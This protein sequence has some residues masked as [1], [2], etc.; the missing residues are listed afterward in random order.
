MPRYS[1]TIASPWSLE[2]SFAYMADFRHALDWDPSVR[3]ATSDHEVVD[4]GALFHLEVAFAGRSQHL[5]YEVTAFD[6]PHSLTLTAKTPQL[7]SVDTITCTK[8]DT[9][10]FVHYDASLTFLGLARVFNPLLAILFRKLAKNAT[11]GLRRELS[12]LHE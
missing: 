2:E 8:S 11:S 7:R 4:L 3:T 1:V 9:G 10:S 12:Q 5:R 6:A